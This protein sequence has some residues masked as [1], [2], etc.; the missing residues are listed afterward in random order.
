MTVYEG[1]SIVLGFLGLIALIL[2]VWSKTQTDIAML[3]IQIKNSDEKHHDRKKELDDHKAE[4][5]R[6]I[7]K[8]HN[9]NRQD[10][11]LMFGKLDE[12]NRNFNRINCKE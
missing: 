12:I 4:N 2:R 10:H 8:L 7:E 3:Q 11:Q 5:D 9:E 6:Q 1:L